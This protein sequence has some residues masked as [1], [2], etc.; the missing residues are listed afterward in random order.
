VKAWLIVS[1]NATR[2]FLDVAAIASKMSDTALL[3]ALAPLDGLYPQQGDPGAV[4]H[5][6]MRQLALPR[7]FDLESVNLTEYNGLSQ[8]WHDWAT[9]RAQCERIGTLMAMAVSTQ[10]AGWR[11]VKST[12]R[13]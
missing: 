7:P 8:V 6:L 9:V 5:Q 11:N 3:A 10:R 12:S 4:R 2:D 13:K 1:R